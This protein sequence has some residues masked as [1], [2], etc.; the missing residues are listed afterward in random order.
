M[1]VCVQT[2][3]VDVAGLRQR[4]SLILEVSKP[5]LGARISTLPHLDMTGGTNPKRASRVDHCRQVTPQLVAVTGGGERSLLRCDDLVMPG[6][7]LM[8]PKGKAGSEIVELL[9]N[10]VPAWGCRAGQA[11]YGINW[12]GQQIEEKAAMYAIELQRRLPASEIG[13]HCFDARHVAQMDHVRIQD[14][15]RA[16]PSCAASIW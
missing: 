16:H 5:R 4:R 8:R 3:F 1:R 12:I 2:S 7:L 11:G 10:E 9:D 15:G 14:A 13:F 6:D